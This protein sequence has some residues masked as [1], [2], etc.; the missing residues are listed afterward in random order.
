MKRDH[1]LYDVLR[2]RYAKHSA[3]GEVKMVILLS[4]YTVRRSFHGLT[5]VSSSCF[6]L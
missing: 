2:K 3:I 1:E 4:F 6:C 5:F